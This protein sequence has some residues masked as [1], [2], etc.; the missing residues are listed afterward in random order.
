MSKMEH[1]D[2]AAPTEPV[3]EVHN[4][5]L[6]EGATDPEKAQRILD[7]ACSNRS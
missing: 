5:F 2:L 7:A 3:P 1:L 4:K 6:A